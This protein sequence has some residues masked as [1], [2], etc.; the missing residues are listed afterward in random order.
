MVFLIGSLNEPIFSF[1][2]ARQIK[3][4]AVA[5]LPGQIA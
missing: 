1:G 3:R 4:L 5:A 2:Y